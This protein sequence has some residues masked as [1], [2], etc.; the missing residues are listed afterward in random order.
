MPSPTPPLRGPPRCSSSTAT[1]RRPPTNLGVLTA[2]VLD[3]SADMTIA[4][5]PAQIT[6]GGG[7]GLVVGLARRGIEH[8]T[9]FRA[10]QPLSGMRCVS[11]AAFDGGQP[12]R[13]RLGGRDRADRRRAAGR[14]SPC[15]RCPASCS[16][17]SAAATGAARCTGPS[18]TATSGWRSCGAAGGRGTGADPGPPALRRCGAGAAAPR[19]AV[20]P[21][22]RPARP[23]P[24]RLGARAP[25]AARARDRR[26]SRRCCGRHTSLG[27]AG[28]VP[29]PARPG[30][31]AAHL[32]RARRPRPARPAGGAVRARPTTSTTSPTAASSSWAATRGSTRRSPGPGGLDPVTS[33]VEAPWTTEPSVYGPFGTL[34]HGL[35]AWVGGGSLR[36]G[37]WV[38]QL[39]VVLSWLAVRA[40]LRAVLDPD[41]HGRVDVLWTLNP[42]VVGI[43]VLGAHIDVVATALALAAVVVAARRAG[44][45]R[46]RRSA[47]CSWRSP[48]RRSSPTPSSAVGRRRRLVAR[49]SPLG[50]AGP[51][52]RRARRRGSSSWPARCT[53]GR[54]RTSTTSCSARARPCRWRPRGARC[55]S[56]AATP[57]ATGR[58]AR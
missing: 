51:A 18:S 13:P 53:C 44:V 58:P 54:G 31:G 11:P 48:G 6:A 12:A 3:G 7:R 1:C 21:E 25:P 29:R 28:R 56:G 39:L 33:R 26:R 24:A 15:S 10:V 34:L 2:A 43:G 35:S 40:L 8:L 23:R 17:G 4:T 46:G 20:R 22:R 52:G 49:G 30:G 36:E 42:L 14:A 16:T 45:D 50:G 57:G 27:G 41:L 5:L 32:A 19:R 47:G 37:V 55:S 9:G 38:W